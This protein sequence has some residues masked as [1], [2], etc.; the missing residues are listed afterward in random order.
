MRMRDVETS[1]LSRSGRP[2]SLSASAT[3]SKMSTAASRRV[4]SPI[5]GTPA[6][7]AALSGVIGTARDA[8][9]TSSRS[10]RSSS[11]AAGGEVLA[12][13]VLAVL[14]VAEG[15]SS[16]K[17]AMISRCCARAL[18]LLSWRRCHCS[19]YVLSTLATRSPSAECCSKCEIEQSSI[20]APPSPSIST[21]WASSRFEYHSAGNFSEGTATT[22]GAPFSTLEPSGSTRVALAGLAWLDE[23]SW[24]AR[25]GRHSNH[26][27]R[28]AAARLAW[29]TAMA[30]PVSFVASFVALVSSVGGVGGARRSPE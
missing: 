15:S 2:A 7:E 28:S 5:W 19:S 22:G 3:W 8:T 6:P 30:S 9:S 17:D 26:W 20:C 1:T 18:A 13:V 23:S 27:H 25:H 4:C 10:G 29:S 12:L 16:S 14:E 24:Y 11:G 21:L